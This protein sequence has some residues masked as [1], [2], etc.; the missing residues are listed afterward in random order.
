M[1]FFITPSF[2]TRQ[3]MEEAVV[4]RTVR[5]TR[6]S[7]RRMVSPSFTSPGSSA[8]V[9]A[10]RLS[11]P[12]TSSV[13][14]VNSAPEHSVTE[15]SAKVL[16]R[17]SG[18]R[19]SS[20]AATGRSSSSR[21]F[22]SWSR[23]ALCSSW[24]PWEKLN[25]ATFIP[26]RIISPRTP[27]RSVAGPR[28][29][30]IFVFLIIILPPFLNGNRFSDLSVRSHCTMPRPNVNAQIRKKTVKEQGRSLAGGVEAKNRRRLVKRH[31]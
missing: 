15:P 2:S 28:V 16:R 3:R 17:T 21:S 30:T 22:F 7:S 27:S 18:P 25:R 13:V 6:P 12:T 9:M 1:L 19:V 20:M 4:S 8:Y 24:L 31:F 14:R 5:R 11:S 23:R 10:Q 26:A 29:H